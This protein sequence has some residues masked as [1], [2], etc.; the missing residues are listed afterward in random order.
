[1]E[2]TV[3]TQV[4]QFL[5]T[6]VIGIILGAFYDLFR[7]LRIAFCH[8]KILLFVEDLLF[9]II[10]AVVTFFVMLNVVDG[11]VRFFAVLGEILGFVTYHYTAGVIVIAMADVVIKFLGKIFSLL[12]II[13]LRPI[14]RIILFIW[15]KLAIFFG[16]WV[17]KTKKALFKMK[18]YLKKRSRL[19]Y[20]L[21]I[22]SNKQKVNKKNEQTEQRQRK[23]KKK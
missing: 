3:S 16:F 14:L 19:L 22:S 12:Y 8:G 17:Y 11:R 4:M 10:S 15:S 6:C 7:I 20:N 1:M 21:S 5:M 18:Y 9:W 13:F 23:S 2:I